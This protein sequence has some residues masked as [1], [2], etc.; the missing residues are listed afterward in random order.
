M[1]R[2]LTPHK[3]RYCLLL[4]LLIS[5][6]VLRAQAIIGKVIA[7]HSEK[8]KEQPAEKLYLQLDKT[9]YGVSDTLR[10]KAYL[11]NASILNASAKSNI[12]YIELSDENNMV[13][14]R[15]L[16]QLTNGIGWG[17]IPLV[18]RDF[19]EGGYT[20]RAYTQWMLN[21]DESQVFKQQFY[22]SNID[23]YKWLIN[24]NS[25]VK[26]NT[27]QL[28]VKLTG[29][30]KKPIASQRVLFGVRQGES[31]I[32]SDRPQTTSITGELNIPLAVKDNPAPVYASLH[33]GTYGDINEQ[34]YKFPIIYNRPEKADIQF[35]PEGGHLV[36]GIK[37]KVGVKAIG[38]NGK[39]L[40]VS[41]NILN[42]LTNRQV[43]SFVASATGMGSF[44]FVPVAGLAYKAVVDLPGG[45]KKEYPFPEV[46][47]VGTVLS[48]INPQQSDSVIINITSS[49][50]LNNYYMLLGQSKEKVCFAAKVVLANNSK[51]VKAPKT[52]FASGIVRFT[53]LSEQLT[54]LNER[55]VYI[56]H[57][58]NLKITITSHQK[59]YAP[60]DSIALNVQ[61]TD[62]D[63]N[64]VKGTFSMSVITAQPDSGKVKNSILTNLLLTSDIKGEIEDPMYFLTSGHEKQLDDLL[65][66]QGWTGF[67]WKDVMQPPKPMKFK[68][69]MGYSVSGKVDKLFNKPVKDANISITSIKPIM[70]DN[71][72]SDEEGYF[73]FTDLPLADSSA[74]FL[75]STNE[76]GRKSTFDI[77]LD[78]PERPVFAK[79]ILQMP[80]Y[81]NTDTAI[82]KLVD[83]VLLNQF[84]NEKL[85]GMGNVLGEVNIKERR[86][87]RNS[88]NLNGPG[89]AD[90]VI[91]TREIEKEPKMSLLELLKK[92]VKGFR[93][94][95]LRPAVRY[96]IGSNEITG[97]IFDGI[98]PD[99]FYIRWLDL[100]DYYTSDDI[101]GVEVMDFYHNSRY[102][103]KFR[104]KVKS[105]V[106]A[107]LEITT[108][109][110]DGPF[111]K[112]TNGYVMHR[113]PV[114]ALAKD[115]YRPRYTIKSAAVAALDER[116]TIHWEP[117]IVTDKDG[118]ATVSFYA[119]GQ[120]ATYTVTMEGSNMDG[121]LGSDVSHISVK[122]ER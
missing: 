87:V 78:K 55:I 19:A 96:F 43:G 25:T 65:L 116:T 103:L 11:F 80:W 117:N 102:F 120:A 20:L 44:D 62:K 50:G 72:K 63:N 41:G 49:P 59:T 110:L 9:N 57:K 121:S 89:E 71:T 114:L 91:D 86:I 115:F 10:F 37:T 17:S 76:K 75:N 105:P 2:I 51:T 95:G 104:P 107:Y 31:L 27:A 40:N 82:L 73:E 93:T 42:S 64:P 24:V 13:Q 109:G 85:S 5:S 35:M 99:Q 3:L 108:K 12:V 4:L 60:Q 47:A 119:A 28:N 30:D 79:N 38:E 14:A 16:V 1:P 74:F 39:G 66:T 6:T 83:T 7:S 113:A 81:V 15:R 45:V 69:E 106:P 21:F 101:A 29:I 77:T 56:D 54:T 118:K 70:V 112:K 94:Q 92:K 23:K 100:L 8:Q 32:R 98:N 26:D 90:Q 84:S 33:K 58:D 97:M 61:V 88:L 34:V 18:K 53:L 22:V 67:D 52:A 46:K 122:Q 48:V 36:A 111:L 68:A